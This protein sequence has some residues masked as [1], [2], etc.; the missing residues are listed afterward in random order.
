MKDGTDET[1]GFRCAAR[2]KCYE[3][4]EKRSAKG[5]QSE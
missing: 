1:I 2:K 4:A 5:M 3:D